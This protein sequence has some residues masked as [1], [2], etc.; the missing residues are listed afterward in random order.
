MTRSRTFTDAD[1]LAAV[2]EAAAER[3]GPAVTALVRHQATLLRQQ[4]RANA[5]G[6]PGPNVIT[7]AYRDSWTVAVDAGAP[8]VVEG[9]V[10]TT[11]PQGRRLEFGFV[12][13]DKLGRR[14]NQPPFPHVAP[15]LDSFGRQVEGQLK[16]VGEKVI[17]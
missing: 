10:G 12:G 2:L 8:G 13:A 1:Q 6:R 7:G 15:A 16:A 14:Y 4:I 11:A 3:V 5:S 9:L 17:G